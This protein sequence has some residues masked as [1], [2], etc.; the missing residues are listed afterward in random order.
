MQSMSRGV[1]AAC[2]LDRTRRFLVFVR[3]LYITVN[4]V[5]VTRFGMKGGPIV[6]FDN[7]FVLNESD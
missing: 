7:T 5:L 2:N 4:Y 1:S 6:L 3:A